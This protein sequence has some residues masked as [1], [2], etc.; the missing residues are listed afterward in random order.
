[1]LDALIAAL[2][3]A[4]ADAHVRAVLLASDLPG[5]F[6]AGLDMKKLLASTPVQVHALL[7]R[8]YIKLYDAQ[9]NLTKPSISE[10]AGA[11]RGGGM[12]VAISSDMIVAADTATFGYPEIDVGVL[13]AI[14]YAHLPAIVG[15]R[16]AARIGPGDARGTGSAI[17][18][19]GAHAG[20]IP[21]VQAAAGV[22]DGPACFRVR[23]R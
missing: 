17:A 11:V 4:N 22:G 8:L 1:M 15:K 12:T 2:E 9:F 16:P 3:R 10:V 23:Q 5:R 7:T 20:A 21:G 13:P 19:R 6:C 18:V 14:H